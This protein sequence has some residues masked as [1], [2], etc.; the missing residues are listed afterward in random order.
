MF[1]LR[2]STFRVR[3]PWSVD[4]LLRCAFCFRPWPDEQTHARD[5]ALRSVVARLLAAE[6]VAL[7][8]IP[9]LHH[10]ITPSLQLRTTPSLHHSTTPFSFR[11]TSLLCVVFGGQHCDVFGP[12]SGQDFVRGA[13]FRLAHRQCLGGLRPL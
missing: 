2:C 13:A 6:T 3:G 12:E 5:L 1:D 4:L 9:P 11:E 8:L 7:V 10:S